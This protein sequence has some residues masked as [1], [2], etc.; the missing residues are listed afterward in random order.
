MWP[1]FPLYSAN[2]D[3]GAKVYNEILKILNPNFG[4]INKRRFQNGILRAVGKNWII[5]NRCRDNA[6]KIW[7]DR[8]HSTKK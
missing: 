7:L 8:T 3:F 5:K 4:H 1:Q 2:F 6:K